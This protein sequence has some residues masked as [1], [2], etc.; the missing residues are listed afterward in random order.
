LAASGLIPGVLL[1]SSRA[2]LKGKKIRVSSRKYQVQRCK[3]EIC[4]D[5][6][7]PEETGISFLPLLP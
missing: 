6:I 1:V 4:D 2:G 5:E 3:P 7:Y